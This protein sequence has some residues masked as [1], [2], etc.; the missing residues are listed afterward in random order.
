MTAK[1]NAGV[2]ATDQA[3]PELTLPAMEHLHRWT[4]CTRENELPPFSTR[5]FKDLF[6]TAKPNS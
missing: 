5:L 1:G 2:W 3:C 6:V 4:F